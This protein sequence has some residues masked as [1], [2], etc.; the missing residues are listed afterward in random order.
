MY[1]GSGTDLDLARHFL[2][3]N[4]LVAIPTETVYG[5]A[6]NGLE[7]K[8]ILKIFQA[9]NR[10][11]FDPLILHCKSLEQASSLA[12]E[13]PAVL[14]DLTKRFWPGPLTI[15]LPKN[16][17][18]PDLITSGQDRVALRV[19]AHPLTLAL[20]Q[21]LD[22][23]LAAPS[24]NPFGYISPTTAAHVLQQLTGKLA[25]V[26]DGGACEVGLEST[27]VGLEAD[28]LVVYRK[29]GLP[30]EELQAQVP[31]SIQIKVIEH[32]SSRPE[33]PGQLQSHYAPS[34]KLILTEDLKSSLPSSVH[35]ETTGL[36]LFGDSLGLNTEH[37]ALTLNLS[38]AGDLKEAA[39]HLFS[40]MRRLD[41][42][43]QISLIL[44]QKLPDHGLGLAINDRLRRASA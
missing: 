33:S 27:I 37:F 17:R 32:S 42:Q 30:V 5:L 11:F 23:P 26:L 39:T 10:P 14:K 9:K 34:K 28:Q 25:Y 20:L 13:F 31:A 19:P 12:T 7:P 22:Y 21:K 40:F 1:T 18:V 6:G 4:E 3:L 29:G 36:L 35:P 38:P 15:L 43:P 41:D 16:D 44:A 24:A 8:A 2:D